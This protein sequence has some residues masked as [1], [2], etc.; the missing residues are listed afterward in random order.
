MSLTCAE[1]AHYQGRGGLDMDTRRNIIN[2]AAHLFARHGYENTSLAQVARKAEVSKALIFWHFENK[3]ALFDEVIEQTIAPYHIV[4]GA[5]GSLKNLAPADAL[6]M[7][8]ERYTEFVLQHIESV[9]FFLSLFLREEKMPDAFFAQVI[10][11]Y[12]QFRS[13]IGDTIQ[14]GQDEGIFVKEIDAEIRAALMMSTLNGI[15]VQGLTGQSSAVGSVELVAAL[16]EA[17]IDSLKV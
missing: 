16:K 12:R 7:I 15:L 1:A 6:E 3:E 9:R 2:I 13:L 4:G 14:R 8:A 10:E 5:I 11:L 17:L